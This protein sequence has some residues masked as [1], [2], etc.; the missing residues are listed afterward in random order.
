VFIVIFQDFISEPI[1]VKQISGPIGIKTF[2]LGVNV[3]LTNDLEWAS[4]N[5][6]TCGL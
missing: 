5:Y 6:E 3:P 4:L 2:S 1:G